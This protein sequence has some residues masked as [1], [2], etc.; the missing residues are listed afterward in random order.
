VLQ[1]CVGGGAVV[2][3]GGSFG[4]IVVFDISVI[5]FLIGFL[6]IGGFCSCGFA[7]KRM[8]IF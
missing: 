6:V 8:M 3:T 5:G 1:V 7:E 2:P 4:V